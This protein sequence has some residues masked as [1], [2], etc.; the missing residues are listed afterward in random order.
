MESR[1]RGRGRGGE[2]GMEGR[3][4]EWVQ[5]EGVEEGEGEDGRGR[6]REEHRGALMK[7]EH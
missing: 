3:V 7:T 4:E 2:T 5:R 6:W 1:G